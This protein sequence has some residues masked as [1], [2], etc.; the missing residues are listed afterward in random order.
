MKKNILLIGLLFSIAMAGK[1]QDYTLDFDGGNDYV[2]VGAQA[3]LVMTATVTI[4]AWVFPEGTGSG[5]A[6]GGIIVNKEGEYEIARFQNGY[7]SWAF[8]NNNPGWFWHTTPAFLPLNQ[9]SHVAIT[10][11]S[12]VVKSYL[13]GEL[14]ETYNGAGNI[15]DVNP[16]TNDFRIGGRQG[17]SQFFNGKIEEVRIFNSVRTIDEIRDNVYREL[18]NPLAEPGLVAY[19]KFNQSSG[20]SA[21]DHSV[22]GYNGTLVNMDPAT[23]WVI[24]TAPNPYENIAYEKLKNNATW[25][26]G[27][28]SP[29]LSWARVQIMTDVVV[30][31]Q[32]DALEV[33][34]DAGWSLTIAPGASLTV[35][36]VINNNAGA[37]G[38]VV[39]SDASGTGSLIEESGT[40]ATVERYFSGNDP[41]WHLIGS[42]VTNALSDVFTGMYLQQYDEG[43]GLY[44]EITSTT[45]PLIPMKGYAV[46]SNLSNSN[47]A[48][49]T[50]NLN[51]GVVTTGLTAVNPFGWNLLSNPFPSSVDWEAVNVPPSINNAIYY[52]DAATGNFLSYI[53]GMGGGMQYIPPMQGFF[54][55]A[56]STTT[57]LFDNTFRTH[58]GANT[59]Y[60]SS[61]NNY[62]VVMAEGNGFE[63]KTYIR[64][65]EQATDSFDGHFDAYKLMSGHNELLPQVYTKAGADDLSINVL[66]EP[67]MMHLGFEAG[68]SGIYTLSAAKIEDIGTV[69]LEDLT[70]GAVTDLTAGNYSFT[71]D[72][73]DDPY[74]FVLHFAPL[75]TGET[76]E[77]ALAKVYSSGMDIYVQ[78][79][80]DDEGE[81]RVYNLTGQELVSVPFEGSGLEK[82]GMDN[83]TGY[84]IVK[85]IAR[86]SVHS[87]KVFLR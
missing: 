72:T 32:E 58:M 2:N 53:G 44:S 21:P 78:T 47:T 33:I 16:S 22:S 51:T 17:T 68:A 85:I 35:A 45:E 66:P 42:P 38:L 31:S 1:A 11:Q 18:Q 19:Y 28:L 71:Y 14:V 54:V 39:Q 65:D 29:A 25:N 77:N 74:R 27:Q 4:E 9:W 6:Q 15:G 36:G 67:V 61:F 86:G 56:T 87:E 3:G 13:N 24:S 10:Y 57:L 81:I 59:F 34:I 62:L 46:Y 64:F 55:S 69:L 50:G 43:T 7:L 49:F 79:T 82:I 20:T 76:A 70:D 30:D 83:E 23:D 52:L 73:G 12:G 41:D 8:A 48:I 40:E 75:S 26:T 37:A 63:D 84:Y 60:K 80:A 5:G